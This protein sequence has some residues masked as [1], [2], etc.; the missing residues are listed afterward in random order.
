[1]NCGE[2]RPSYTVQYGAVV[3]GVGVACCTV[4]STGLT[5]DQGKRAQESGPACGGG[6]I[7]ISVLNQ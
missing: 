4:M 7:N 2:V 5:K 3:C 1:M 6:N